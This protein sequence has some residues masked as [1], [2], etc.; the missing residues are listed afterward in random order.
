[1]NRFYKLYKVKELRDC[2]VFPEGVV[3][4]PYPVA[5][6]GGKAYLKVCLDEFFSMKDERNPFSGRDEMR[7]GHPIVI[8]KILSRPWR[9]A[10]AILLSDVSD[11]LFDRFMSKLEVIWRLVER[12]GVIHIDLRLYN[13]FY[14][15]DH[16]E[17]H[18]K[19]IA[20]DDSVLD[21][22]YVPQELFRWRCNY[23][24]IR[25]PRTEEY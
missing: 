9:L 23:R 17:V 13:I 3:D 22:R 18:V 10:A 24:D 7:P 6:K 2:I 25:F 11:E 16:N 8:Y 12:A 21:G 5:Q 19:I 14:V 1:M 4:Y 15:D 20:W